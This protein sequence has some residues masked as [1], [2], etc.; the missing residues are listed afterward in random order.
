MLDKGSASVSAGHVVD[1]GAFGME[2][3]EQERRISR[4]ESGESGAQ[5]VVGCQ[6]LEDTRSE[7]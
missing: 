5:M 2:I 1:T 3:L 7:A 6:Q 4:R